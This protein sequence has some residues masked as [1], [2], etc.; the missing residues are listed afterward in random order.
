MRFIDLTMPRGRN[1]TEP[2]RP[3]ASTEPA[4]KYPL[5]VVLTRKPTEWMTSGMHRFEISPGLFQPESD[6]ASCQE[7]WTRGNLG[8]AAMLYV[9]RSCVK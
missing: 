2:T 9:G 5:R 7:I 3:F 6:H 4:I 8:M 1:I